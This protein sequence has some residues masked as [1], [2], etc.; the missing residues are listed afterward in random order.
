M[1]LTL[2][3]EDGSI[4]AG[5]NSYVDPT[6]AVAVDFFDAHLYAT[7]WAGATA[8]DRTKACIM[9][10]RYVDQLITWKGAPVE[11]DQPL[12]WPREEVLLKGHSDYLPDDAIPLDIVHAV[13]ETAN[14]FL[15][16]DRV[17]DTAKTAGVAGISLGQGALDLTFQQPDPQHNLSI[18]PNQVMLLLQKYGGGVESGFRQIPISR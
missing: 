8:D 3:V 14:A 9:A 1:A 15:N 17:S 11:N 5:A 12:A 2:T 13:L 7:A 10:T 6:S 18:I 16:G 4:V